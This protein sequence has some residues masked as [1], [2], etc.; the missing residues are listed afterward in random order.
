MDDNSMMNWL[1]LVGL[2][3][4]LGHVVIYLWST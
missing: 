1:S 2:L 3:Y 4:I